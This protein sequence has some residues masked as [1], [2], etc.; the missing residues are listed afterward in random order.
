MVMSGLN[1]ALVAS[2]EIRSLQALR[3]FVLS[4]PGRNGRFDNTI[5]LGD[6]AQIQVL[7]ADP[8]DSAAIYH[9]EPAVVLGVSMRSGQN[10]QAFGRSLKA[11]KQQL[12]EEEA[13]HA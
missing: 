12:Q 5:R 4:V 11:L 8:P 1:S 2:G 3:E 9:G 10:I 13:P 6:I 7:P